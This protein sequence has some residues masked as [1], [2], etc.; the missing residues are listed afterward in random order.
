[1]PTPNINAFMDA[2]VVQACRDC[3]TKQLDF[4]LYILLNDSL[5][6]S[7]FIIPQAMFMSEHISLNER[8]ACSIV[9][10]MNSSVVG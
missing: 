1:M 9:G 8:I 7:R 10:A 2:A 6:N 3:A 4:Q 5:T